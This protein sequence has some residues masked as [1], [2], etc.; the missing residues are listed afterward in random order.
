[1]S[2][3][4]EGLISRVQTSTGTAVDVAYVSHSGALT[5]TCTACPWHERIDT[6]ALPTDPPEKEDL[7]V[8]RHLPE[9]ESLAQA[10]AAS[11]H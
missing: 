9:A 3:T 4:P 8:E 5:T 10:H 11:Q 7:L 6:G 1:M 2:S